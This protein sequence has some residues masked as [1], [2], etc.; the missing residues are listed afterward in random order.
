MAGFSIMLMNFI[1]LPLLIV[2]SLAMIGLLFCLGGLAAAGAIFLSRRLAGRQHDRTL[3][4]RCGNADWMAALLRSANLRRF[5]VMR[6]GGAG[7]LIAVR[8]GRGVDLEAHMRYIAS[9]ATDIQG[10]YVK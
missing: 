1:L 10:M 4:I 5:Q 2:F 8:A 3:Y 7:A 6:S 9:S